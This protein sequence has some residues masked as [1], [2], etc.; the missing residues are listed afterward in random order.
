MKCGGSRA[1]HFHRRYF[2]MWKCGASVPECVSECVCMRSP[3]QFYIFETIVGNSIM[4]NDNFPFFFFFLFCAVETARHPLSR[5]GMDVVLA[6][7]I[8]LLKCQLFRTIRRYI[9]IC[10]V[11][12]IYVCIIPY[13]YIH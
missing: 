9:E 7:H 2:A 5:D 6:M 11:L 8:R 1:M 4:Y 10:A 12:L 13:I 3:P